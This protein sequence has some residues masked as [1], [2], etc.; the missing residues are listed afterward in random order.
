MLYVEDF[1]NFKGVHL[2]AASYTA[3]R[4]AL[5]RETRTHTHPHFSSVSF[6]FLTPLGGD[7]IFLTIVGVA[8]KT[9]TPP[10]TEH[11]LKR[12]KQPLESISRAQS[13]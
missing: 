2:L 3:R 13:G 8:E 11:P 1:K 10:H 7:V 4:Q 9:N 5:S 6:F 12:T